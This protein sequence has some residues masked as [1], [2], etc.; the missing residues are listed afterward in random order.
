MEL[1]ELKNRRMALIKEMP[2]NSIAILSAADRNYRSRDVENPYRQNSDF[3]YMTGLSEPNLINIIYEEEDIVYSV[4]FRNNTTEHEKIWDGSRLDN[5]EVMETYG[6][7]E[8]QSYN[9][10]AEKILSYILNKDSLYI[11]SGLND[12]LDAFISDQISISG[13]NNRKNYVFPKK[14]VALHSVTQK[15]RLIKSN[16]EIGL[17]KEAAKVSIIGHE[18]A[19]QKAKPGLYEYELDAEI[20]YIFNK[21]NMHFAYMSIVGG[22]NNACTLHYIKNNN[23]LKDQDLVLIDAAAENQGYASDITRTFPVNGKYTKEQ[24]LVYDV[25]LNAQEKAIEFIK[26]GVTWDQVHKITVEEIAKGLV[27]L[28]LVPNDIERVVDEELYK[29]FFM[30]KTGHWL[31]L[32][33][34]DVG[35]YENIL[36]EPG[37]VITVEPGIYINSLNENIPKK[38]R[39]IGIRIEDDVLITKNGNEVITKKLPKKR[40]E[41]EVICNKSNA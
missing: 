10:Y 37:M 36:F 31:G 13:K 15:L 5:T 21:N 26:P 30:H 41:I 8:I 19:M 14:I 12:E 4:L 1:S 6:F 27:V 29:D 35:E 22:G 24:A 20:K 40:H 2:K 7:T 28:G 18:K 33:V 25:V 11:E 38:W 23:L 16:Y 34:H 3:L 17:I 32:D 39:G 9:D